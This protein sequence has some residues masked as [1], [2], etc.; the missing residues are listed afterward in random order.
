[1]RIKQITVTCDE[2]GCPAS[3]V[4]ADSGREEVTDSYLRV[5]GW[6]ILMGDKG[7]KYEYCPN[8]GMTFVVSDAMELAAV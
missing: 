1:M 8:H 6:A 3:I 7:H 2:P 5:R 4:L